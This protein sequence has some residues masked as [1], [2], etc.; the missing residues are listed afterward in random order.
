MPETDL[1]EAV[2]WVGA[3]LLERLGPSPTI[4][5]ARVALSDAIAFWNAS[6]LAS[7]RWERPSV[8]ALNEL[9]K[10]LGG[11]RASPEGR[12]AFQLVVERQRKHWL[13]PRL[14]ASWSYEADA[15]GAPR[16]K[17]TMKLPEGVRAETRPPAEK[18][19]AIGGRYLDELSIALG[20]GHY[21]GFPVERHRGV[22]GEDGTATVY[23]MMPSAL[24]L[25]AAGVLPAIG[26]GP[27]EVAIGRRQL[28]PMRLAEVSCGSEDGR[29]DV[30]ILVFKPASS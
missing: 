8:K 11:P 14:V 22:V 9:T 16:L 15:G 28:G 7:K 20:S 2:L 25:F 23:A 19:I 1:A 10:R 17:C 4:E 27:V 30:A 3:P 12:A 24:Q 6:V 29:H 26:A 13:D 18:R 5:D 21:L